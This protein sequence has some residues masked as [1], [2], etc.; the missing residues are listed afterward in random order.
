MVRL[1]MIW[2]SRVISFK[3][4]FN[5]YNSLILSILLYGCETWTLLE[6]SKKLL[7]AFEP[8]SHRRM[9]NITYRQRKKNVYINEEMISRIGSYERVL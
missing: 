5:L 1:E 2:R 8:N 3:I 4:K 6:E 9:I 7:N